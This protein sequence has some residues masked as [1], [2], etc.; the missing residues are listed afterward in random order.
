[1]NLRNIFVLVLFPPHRF[2]GEKGSTGRS[3]KYFFIINKA[4]SP[5]IVGKKKFERDIT[6]LEILKILYSIRKNNSV[7]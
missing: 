6:F 3:G 4:I 2:S 5:A 1:M 7:N